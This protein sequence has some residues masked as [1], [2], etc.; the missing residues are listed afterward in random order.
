MAHP[1]KYLPGDFDYTRNFAVARREQ[2]RAMHNML[3]T[4][5]ANIEK[6]FKS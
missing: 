2:A 4:L 1:N 6:L 5:I 3:A